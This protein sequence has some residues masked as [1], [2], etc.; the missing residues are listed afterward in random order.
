MNKLVILLILTYM[1]Q[2]A[3]FYLGN[4]SLSTPTQKMP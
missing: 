3:L 2:N 4:L 1:I